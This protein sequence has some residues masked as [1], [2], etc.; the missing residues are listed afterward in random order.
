MIQPLRIP[1]GWT[2]VFNEFTDIEPMEIPAENEEMWL[3]NFSEDLLYLSAEMVHKRNGQTKVQKLGIDLGWYPEG[4]PDGNFRLQAI[5]DENWENPLLEFSS[6][7][8][9]EIVQTLEKWLFHEFM[10]RYFVDEDLFRK[11]HKS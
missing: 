1:G 9:D 2:V 8:K 5:L 4:N 10:Q 3:Y 7:N 6:R 11:N